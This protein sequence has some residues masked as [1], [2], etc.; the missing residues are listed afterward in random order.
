MR[1]AHLDSAAVAASVLRSE[2]SR[3]TRAG[4]LI[5]EVRRASQE[6]LNI[7]STKEEK[8]ETQHAH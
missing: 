6:Q 4:R 5:Y 2:A 7:P 8:E 3:S 1:L